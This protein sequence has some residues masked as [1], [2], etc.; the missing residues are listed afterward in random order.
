MNQELFARLSFILSSFSIED[1]LSNEQ[2]LRILI[3]W[4]PC[5]SEDR[6]SMLR[7][8]GVSVGKGVFIDFGVWIDPVAPECIEIEDY[9][10][11]A[12]GSSIVSHHSV[13]NTLCNLPPKRR[14]TIMKKNSRLSSN[15]MILPGVVVGENSIVAA[16]AVVTKDVQ[17]NTVVAGNPAKPIHTLE[18]YTKKYLDEVKY[19]SDWFGGD[20]I[21]DIYKPPREA[22]P[23]FLK[24]IAKLNGRK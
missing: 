14:K 15:A 18:E 5:S 19:H 4:L 11:L 23:D 24:E 13:M 22:L 20:E 8:L 9:A 17:P 2:A 12:Y 7:E 10:S 16:G 6:C 21:S 3:M 1:W